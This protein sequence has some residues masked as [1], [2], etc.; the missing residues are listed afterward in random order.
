M[1]VLA[2]VVERPVLVVLAE[3]E[4]LVNKQED[5]V[6][7]VLGTCQGGASTL[8]AFVDFVAVADVVDDSHVID[9]PKAEVHYFQ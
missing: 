1:P 5:F 3:Q 6:V 7:A 4:A 2:P 9:S 8:G